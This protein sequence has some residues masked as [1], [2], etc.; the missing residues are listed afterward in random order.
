ML[1]VRKTLL[2]I[3][4]LLL[5]F[6]GFAQQKSLFNINVGAS[7]FTGNSE[8]SYFKY[9]LAGFPSVSLEKDFNLRIHEKDRFRFSP[10]LNCNVL[11][12]FYE[13]NGLADEYESDFHQSALSVYSKF[14]LISNFHQGGNFEL[15][16]GVLGGFQLITRTTGTVIAFFNCKGCP[17]HVNEKVNESGSDFYRPFYYGFFVG[18]TPKM[19]RP[20]RLSPSFEL[21]YLPEMVKTKTYEGGI[22]Q[23]TILLHFHKVTNS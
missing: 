14:A 20:T 23:F 19:D 6:Q 5:S 4:F 17:G 1:I 21:S 9:H 12:E 8:E 2:P 3:L 7:L 11:H 10:G 22:I 18:L 16:A 15:Y 13:I